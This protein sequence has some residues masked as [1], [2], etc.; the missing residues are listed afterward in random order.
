MSQ[1]RRCVLGC[2]S[3]T[4]LFGLP[5]EEEK[6]NQWLEFIYGTRPDQYNLNI[7][8][9]FRHFTKDSYVNWAQFNSG[10]S[11]RLLLKDGSVPTLFDQPGASVSQ[12]QDTGTT[13]TRFQEVG[14]QTDHP[15]TISVGTQS[16]AS[17][18]MFSVGTQL[19]RGTLREHHMRSKG[20]QATVS[21]VSV[22]T[23][24]TSRCDIP[25]SST[26]IKGQLV[27][28]RKR[29]RLELEEEEEADTSAELL[30]STYNPDDFVLTEESDMSFV[31]RTA[32]ADDKYV[33]F[34][35]RLR[36]L[37]DNCPV[38][39][40]RCDVRR[41]RIGTYVAF[42]QFCPKCNYS[43]QWQS[44]PMVR[45]TPVGNLL[46]SAATYFTGASF[47][48]LEKIFK[49]M[50]LQIFPSDTF[51]MHARNFL[52]PAIIHK[53]TTDQQILLQQLKQKGTLRLCGDMRADSP[54]HPA[55][56]GSYT[57]MHLESNTILDLQLVQS[58][59]V[60]GSY[61]ME[62]EGLKRCLDLLESNG[63]VVDY[64]V[65]DRHPQIQKFLRERNIA[66]FYDVLHFVKGL[67]KKLDKV[68]QNKECVVLRKW[69]RSIKNHLYW[70]AS[71]SKTGPEK[72]AKW[73]S[74]VNHIQN[75]HKHENPIFP[76]CEHLDRVSRDPAKWFQP[77]SVA[78]H[79]VK[80]IL[81]NKRV[82]KDV[83]KLSQ[84]FQTS[85]LEAFHRLILLFTPKNVV[86]PFL[87]RL[88]RL[89]LAAMHYNENADYSQATT[90][91][92]QAVYKD[93]FPKSEKGECPERTVKTVPTYNYVDDLMRLVFEEVFEDPVPFAEEMHK[94]SIPKDLASQYERPSKE[95]VAAQHVSLFSQVAG[96]CRRIDQP[97]Q[98]TPGLSG[99]QHR[100]GSQS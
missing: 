32:Y 12:L 57:V 27:R 39:N 30:D 69:L 84:H 92:G 97:D 54:G 66:Q 89:Y 16:V 52:E 95:E 47:I 11:K 83:E 17:K 21:C 51:R 87:G 37:F 41:L 68:A 79:K 6:K 25:L 23:K 38:C 70:S 64:I 76:K 33:V 45:S 86:F 48:Q 7:F 15:Q 2:A 42:N 88:C 80:K 96:G 61:H 29:P 93:V 14:C 46:L 72:V 78:L 53:W 75:V 58:N 98:E 22:G 71:S 65:T 67:S 28:P 18:K 36:E 10:F 3:V 43:R 82:L 77:G 85:S 63:L 81:C 49:A 13:Q 24:T 8:L 90:S 26:S 44:Q 94:I 4:Q 1:W 50:Q 35:S 40:T 9:C 74:L 99:V 73:T 60:H 59:E 19:S 20:T 100:T 34:E 31:P 91:L 56:Y 55:N 62:K 5:K